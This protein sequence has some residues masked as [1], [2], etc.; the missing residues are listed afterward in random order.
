MSSVLP[1]RDR[2][3][4]PPQLGLTSKLCSWLLRIAS[5]KM[6]SIF[7]ILSVLT[8]KP[9]FENQAVFIVFTILSYAVVV[10]LTV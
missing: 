9:Y 10:S 8:F 5:F 1:V 3:G 6:K 4:T 7:P 2:V